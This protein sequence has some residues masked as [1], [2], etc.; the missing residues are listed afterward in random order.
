MLKYYL[1]GSAPSG[2]DA[3]KVVDWFDEHSNHDPGYAWAV[4][5]AKV[6]GKLSKMKNIFKK[7]LGMG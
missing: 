5:F 6:A 2:E 4:A 7:R 1:G 3:K